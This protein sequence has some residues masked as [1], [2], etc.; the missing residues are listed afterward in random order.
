MKVIFV[1]HCLL[2]PAV[3]PF[4]EIDTSVIDELRKLGLAIEQMPCPEVGLYNVKR[5]P[6]TRDELDVYEYRK[7]VRNYANYVRKLIEKF[8]KAG[9]QV[10]AI[11]GFRYSPSCGVKRTLF[12]PNYL[13]R[14][15]ARASGLFIEEI[16]K[17]VD[18]PILEY[19]PEN[20]SKLIDDVR[21]LIE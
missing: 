12:G 15:E 6:K 13:K 2:N 10:V 21:C 17:L 1:A 5:K 7:V 14:R 19:D 16:K 3:N 9:I 4:Y 18:V 20:P 11:V 8:R